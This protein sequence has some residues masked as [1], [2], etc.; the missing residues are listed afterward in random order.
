MGSGSSKSNIP[1]TNSSKTKI[2][3]FQIQQRKLTNINFLPPE[4]IVKIFDYHIQCITSSPGSRYCLSCT[5]TTKNK[6]TLRSVC[7]R[8]FELINDCFDP[9]FIWFNP[10]CINRYYN[11]TSGKLMGK[12]HL[13]YVFKPK[14]C[15]IENYN[16]ITHLKCR[17]T[18][19][20]TDIQL[21]KLTNL[22]DLSLMYDALITDLGLSKMT[23]LEILRLPFNKRITIRGIIPLVNLKELYITGYTMI[24][25]EEINNLKNL[26]SMNQRSRNIK[27]TVI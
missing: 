2:S 4:I 25:E 12:Y 23:N 8:W 27:V 10:D 13:E 7:F 26:R 17:G 21:N 9:I 6:L 20:I 5:Y 11:F 18:S 16:K 24:S 15:K 1:E 14:D 3:C 19:G 22:I